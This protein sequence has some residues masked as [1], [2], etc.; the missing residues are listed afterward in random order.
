[1]KIVQQQIKHKNTKAFM[2]HLPLEEFNYLEEIIQEYSILKYLIAHEKEPYSHFHFVIEFEKEADRNYHN[3]C[4]RVFKDKYKLRGQATK[5]K[6]RQYGCLKKIENIEKM[7]A[8]TLKEGNFKTNMFQEDIDKYIAISRDNLKT[9]D[10]RQK[11]LKHLEKQQFK[12]NI[13]S[14]SWGSAEEQRPLENQIR[15]EIIKYVVTDQETNYKLTKNIIEN[16]YIEYLQKTKHLG[17]DEKIDALYYKF[18]NVY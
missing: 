15:M 9:L 1:M 17:K 16:I 3:F 8:Y 13:N 2:A 11:I 18:Y 10:Y 6:P 12:N 5:G 7:C 14:I 4:K